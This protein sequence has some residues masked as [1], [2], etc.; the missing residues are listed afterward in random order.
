MFA[1]V[2]GVPASVRRERQSII[3]HRDRNKRHE[4]DINKTAATKSRNRESR[5]QKW[6][7]VVAWHH[8]QSAG[9]RYIG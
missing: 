7:V 6:G 9:R 8:G 5:E 1:K 2:F 3:R 4:H